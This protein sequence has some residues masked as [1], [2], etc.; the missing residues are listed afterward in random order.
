MTPTIRGAVAADREGVCN[1]LTEAGLPLDGLSERLE[2]FLVAE[3]DGLIVAAAG[4]ERYGDSVLVRS[5]VVDPSSRGTGLGRALSE[6][7]LDTARDL[8]ARRAF[9]L[10][11]TAEAFF[12]RLDF[13]VIER[14]AVPA[15][16]RS[17][18]EFAVACPASA[19]VMV[20]PVTSA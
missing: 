13:V 11:N 17:S 6:A 1:L 2:H 20:R 4:M 3:E 16:I 5:V 8:G 12:R 18:V 9:L 7:V 19:V 15:E 10:T 14:A